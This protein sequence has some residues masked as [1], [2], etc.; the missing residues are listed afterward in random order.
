L[1][2]A[3]ELAARLPWALSLALAAGTFIVLTVLSAHFAHASSAS[4]GADAMRPILNAVYGTAAS[5]GR[6]VLAAVFLIGA[7]ASWWGRRPRAGLFTDAA[8]D[9]AAVE[10]L[11]WRE[12]ERLIGE[13]YRRQGIHRHRTWWR[14]T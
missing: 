6:W 14:W 13:A 12:F 5:L 7:G 11:S 2:E 8:R 3:I 10:H 4:R 9:P 1:D